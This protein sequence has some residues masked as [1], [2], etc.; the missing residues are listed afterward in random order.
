[1]RRDEGREARLLHAHRLTVSGPRVGQGRR[2]DAAV[3]AA[4]DEVHGTIMPCPTVTG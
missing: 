2:E 4:E 3:D 1:V